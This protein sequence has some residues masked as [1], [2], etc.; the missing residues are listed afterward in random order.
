[1]CGRGVEDIEEAAQVL[2]EMKQT[3]IDHFKQVEYNRRMSQ[4]RR[5]LG[6]IETLSRF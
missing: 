4:E 6:L 2:K 1:M 3:E 5:T